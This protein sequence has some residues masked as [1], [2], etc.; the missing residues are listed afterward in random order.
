[1]VSV[2]SLIGWLLE[3]QVTIGELSFRWC[4]NGYIH[5]SYTVYDYNGFCFF[6]SCLLLFLSPAWDHTLN[7]PPQMR[8]HAQTFSTWELSAS[9][10]HTSDAACPIRP[11]PP[12]PPPD[13]H[14]G[15]ECVTELWGFCPGPLRGCIDPAHLSACYR[16][17]CAL[18]RS[19][20]SY[21]LSMTDL[22]FYDFQFLHMKN[23][24]LQKQKPPLTRTLLLHLE[25][26]GFMSL[27]PLNSLMRFCVLIW[28]TKRSF[29]IS[30]LLTL[31][32]WAGFNCRQVIHSSG[33]IKEGSWVGVP[34]LDR[35]F[36]SVLLE[37]FVGA[38]R[39]T[40]RPHNARKQWMTSWQPGPSLVYSL[41]LWSIKSDR[42]VGLFQFT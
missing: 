18:L 35:C 30:V 36:L 38:E 7:Q 15:T 41:C 6:T 39:L 14:L 1:M 19:A 23:D 25:S 31:L 37:P 2:A 20:Q 8:A 5:L 16:R 26:S 10:T 9:Q 4:H 11:R 32:A 12:P 3:P 42:Q 22:F 33:Q 29:L 34:E 40:L 13:S 28:W 24:F 27:A 17:A 21:T